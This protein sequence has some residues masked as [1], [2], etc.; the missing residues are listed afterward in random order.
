MSNSNIC[1]RTLRLAMGL[2]LALAAGGC[3]APGALAYKFFGPPSIPARY[4]VPHA[5]L[6]VLVENAH[7]GSIAMPETDA[8]A[9][10]IYEDLLANKVAPLIDP[11]KV[12]DLRDHNPVAFS[13]MSIAEVGRQMGAA[14]VLYVQVDQLEIEAPPSSGVVRLKIALKV[15]MIETETARPTWPD[16][17]DKEPFAV[18]TPWQ[19]I[20]TGTSRTSLYHEILRESGQELAQW[21][22]EFHPET[23]KEENKGQ[24]LR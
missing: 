8:L 3:S 24:K 2:M 16:S 1:S 23:M 10:V 11:D 21:F 7:S 4:K 14:Q 9:Q 6:L 17:G 12:H 22:Y 15:Q 19:R 13:K 18:E 5:P 20:E